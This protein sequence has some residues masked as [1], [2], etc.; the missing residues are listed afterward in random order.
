MA[1]GTIPQPVESMSLGVFQRS[2]TSTGDLNTI[3][4][5][6]IYNWG[7][8]PSNAPLGNNCVMLCINLNGTTCVQVVFACTADGVKMRHGGG[9]SWSNWVNIP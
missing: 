4:A 5:T 9:S 6:G 3:L 1:S 8:A 7:Y 2:I